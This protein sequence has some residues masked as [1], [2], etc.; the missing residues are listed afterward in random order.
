MAEYMFVCSNCGKT[1]QP[2]VAQHKITFYHQATHPTRYRKV[3]DR[4]GN[5]VYRWNRRMFPESRVA[6]SERGE[7]LEVIDFG[8]VGKQ[9]TRELPVCPDCARQ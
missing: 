8:G 7:L 4:K 3:F 1:T 2:R 6:W 9:I 5:P